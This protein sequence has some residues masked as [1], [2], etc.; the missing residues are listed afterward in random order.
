MCTWFNFKATTKI[1]IKSMLIK[2]T[3]TTSQSSEKFYE[4]WIELWVL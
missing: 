1:A 3:K 2:M 4:S